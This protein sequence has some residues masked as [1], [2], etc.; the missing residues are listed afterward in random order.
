M[1]EAQDRRTDEL[2]RKW[3]RVWRW[4]LILSLIAH[5]LIFLLSG[6]PVPLPHVPEAAAGERNG[7]PTA[8]AGGGA[9]LINLRIATAQPS[10]EPEVVEPVPEPEATPEPVPDPEPERK[11][12]Q[13]ASASDG[14]QANAGEGRGT[15]AGPGT[16]TGTGRGDGGTGEEGLYRV[17]APSPRG[18]ILPPT[19]RPSKVRGKSVTVYV[20]V[21]ER[22][23]VVSDSTR[24]APPTGDSRFDNRLKQQAAE[25]SF[26]PATRGGQPIAAW[27]PYTVIL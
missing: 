8:A 23:T 5:V 22:G 21:S 16:E 2:E 15:Q 12:Q 26:R 24:L 18:L 27:F 1:A 11:P 7:D 3:D 25:W 14:Q 10:V 6:Q 20:W 4:S 9:E 13:S 17:T 19:D